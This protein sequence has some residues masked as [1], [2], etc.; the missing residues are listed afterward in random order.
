MDA[1]LSGPRRLL[2]RKAGDSPAPLDSPAPVVDIVTAVADAPTEQPTEQPSP[3]P[4]PVPETV[5]PSEEPT[6]PPSPSPVP[7]ESD[8]RWGGGS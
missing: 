5:A 2:L 6:L 1:P 3:S 7:T 4:E 8:A